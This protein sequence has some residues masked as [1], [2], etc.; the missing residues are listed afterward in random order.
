MTDAQVRILTLIEKGRHFYQ[1]GD[2]LEAQRCWQ[3]VLRV[4]PHHPQ[5]LFL[6]QQL[7]Y[8]QPSSAHQASAHQASAHRA[9]AHQASAHQASAHQA[10]AQ[11]RR[12][13]VTSTHQAPPLAQQDTP[14][15]QH[16]T[17]P[18]IDA[19]FAWPEET[20]PPRATSASFDRIKPTQPSEEED[21][22]F[23][24]SFLSAPPS[25]F[26]A[27]FSQ[28]QQDEHSPSAH[29]SA[30]NDG[31][32]SFSPPRSSDYAHLLF[33][34]LH[35]APTAQ[36][37]SPR[38]SR[39]LL[40]ALSA[41]PLAETDSSP[42]YASVQ[43]TTRPSASAPIAEYPPHLELWEETPSAP[44][45]ERDMLLAA[46]EDLY[47]SED[48][49]GALEML[50]IL[51]STGKLPETAQRLRERCQRF[52]QEEYVTLFSDASQTPRLNVSFQQLSTLELDHRAGFLLSQ[53]D[54]R[55]NLR[56]LLLLSNLPEFNFL[57]IL[58]QLLQ[59]GIIAL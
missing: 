45:D 47:H 20:H 13:P 6:L 1:S 33:D 12:S 39:D 38:S 11:P 14:T 16:N 3:D 44:R 48:Y 22:F 55:T 10:S 49:Q 8:T 54:G 34:D 29:P 51:Q 23:D 32:D 43:Q 9:S 35:L 30:H 37:P 42:H 41:H 18:D 57:R 15:E 59:K 52:L 19:L 28:L 31:D 36:G 25:S 27:R 7:P 56:D 50:E 26:V 17:E 53:I 2:W 21:P 24:D 40:P 5:A 58:H 4:D 46:A